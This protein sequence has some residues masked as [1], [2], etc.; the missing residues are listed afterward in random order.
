MCLENICFRVSTDGDI[1]RDKPDL[2]VYV[3]I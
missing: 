2:H 1:G 3:R